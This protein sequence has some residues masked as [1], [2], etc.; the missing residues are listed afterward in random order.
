MCCIPGTTVVL[1]VSELIFSIVPL[2]VPLFRASITAFPSTLPIIR[3]GIVTPTELSPAAML[4]G[5]VS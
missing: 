5:F 3:A 1:V 4:N 2:T